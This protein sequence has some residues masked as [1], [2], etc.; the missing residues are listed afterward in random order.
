MKG[1][2]KRKLLS[3]IMVELIVD[4]V[5]FIKASMA[6]LVDLTQMNSLVSSVNSVFEVPA[7]RIEFKTYW[8]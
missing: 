6:N 1:F 4:D 2:V 3:R 7:K 8:D 5:T